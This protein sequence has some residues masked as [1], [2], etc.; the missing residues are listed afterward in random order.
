MTSQNQQ[1]S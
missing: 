1:N